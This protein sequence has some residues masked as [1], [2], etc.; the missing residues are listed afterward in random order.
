LFPGPSRDAA[1]RD[2]LQLRERKRPGSLHRILTRLDPAAAARIHWRDRNKTIRALEVR[3]LEGQPMSA[4]F[5][6]GRAPLEGFQPIKLG[7]NP[8]RELL[9]RRLDLRAARIFDRG[10]IGEARSLL[11]SGV[12]ADAKP[13]ESIGYRQALAAVRG[14]MTPQQAL[15]STQLETRRYAKRQ[16]TWFRKEQNIFWLDG[17][18]DDPQV[19]KQALRIISEES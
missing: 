2:R 14:S 13:F 15:E 11:A 9:F 18:G 1:L 3:L 4:L 7:L 17:F 10:L 6:R 8:P 12:S 19:Q 16:L 5:S